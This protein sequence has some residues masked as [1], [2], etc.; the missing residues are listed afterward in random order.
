MC[1]IVFLACYC[2][3]VQ[4]YLVAAPEI[5]ANAL[6]RTH[7]I[8]RVRTKMHINTLKRTRLNFDGIY[9]CCLYM[10]FI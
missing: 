9:V 10:L 1:G 8:T 2:A 7:N 5:H 4:T 6:T 3:V